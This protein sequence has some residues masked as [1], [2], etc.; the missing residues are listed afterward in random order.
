M[1]MGEGDWI[2]SD[3]YMVQWNGYWWSKDLVLCY[4]DILDEGDNGFRLGPGRTNVT[5]SLH[6]KN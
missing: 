6:W 1:V 2:W 4:G 5:Q 3:H